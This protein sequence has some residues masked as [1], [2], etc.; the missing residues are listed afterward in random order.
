MT[1]INEVDS[2]KNDQIS[3]DQMLQIL[4]DNYEK[5]IKL[6]KEQYEQL[7]NSKEEQLAD[8]DKEIAYLRQKIK[9]IFDSMNFNVPDNS[10]INENQDSK[11]L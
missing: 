5:T 10:R 8:K 2:N 7:L 6:L 3:K 1:N 11:S 9:H 4:K